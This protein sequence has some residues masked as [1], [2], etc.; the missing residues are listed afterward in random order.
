MALY[1][2]K[3]WTKLEQFLVKKE[4]SKGIRK[5][6]YTYRSIKAIQSKIY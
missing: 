3:N 2:D 6:R 1:G 4:S 5:P